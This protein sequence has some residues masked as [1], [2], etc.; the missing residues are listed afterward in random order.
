LKGK[1]LINDTILPN[2]ARSVIDCWTAAVREPMSSDSFVSNTAYPEA[3]SKRACVIPAIAAEGQLFGN[4]AEFQFKHS[5]Y[6]ITDDSD[7]LHYPK[8]IGHIIVFP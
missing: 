4:T 1:K 2:F 8:R 5:H 3:D 7:I 6:L